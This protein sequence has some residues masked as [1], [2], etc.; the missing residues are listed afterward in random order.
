MSL[1]EP[2]MPTRVPMRTGQKAQKLADR[3]DT[4]RTEIIDASVE[5]FD[6]ASPR[7]Q[8]ELIDKVRLLNPRPYPRIGRG[9]KKLPT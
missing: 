3:F 2:S 6:L 4:N 5:L 8:R 7:T 1:N 9:N